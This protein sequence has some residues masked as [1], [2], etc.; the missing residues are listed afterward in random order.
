MVKHV[1]LAEALVL[2]ERAGVDRSTAYDVFASGA[3]LAAGFAF[4][5]FL[6]AGFAAAGLALAGPSP[7]ALT[8]G[9]AACALNCAFASLFRSL[10]SCVCNFLRAALAVSARFVASAICCWSVWML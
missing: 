9:A 10:S 8:A 5:A 2:A 7:L 6:A 1:A 3:G 4:G